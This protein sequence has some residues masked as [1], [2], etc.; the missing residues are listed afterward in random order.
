MPGD[1][2]A[3]YLSLL[4]A[5]YFSLFLHEAGHAVLGWWCG[6]EVTSFGLGLDR[7]L[8]LVRW[9]GTRVYFSLTRSTQGIT[10]LIAPMMYPPRYRQILM[11]LGGC[12]ANGVA[13]LTALLFRL[14]LPWGSDVWLVLL[15]WNAWIGLRNLVP[16]QMRLGKFSLRSDGAKVWQ[17]LCRGHLP[18]H[19]EES[20]RTFTAMRPFWEGVF[21]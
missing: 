18:S 10:W 15:G 6:Y 19:V 21:V 11:L 5:M 3:L 14:L 1:H 8:F 4:P 13:A 9:R 2:L 12:L 17:L 20:I 7:P 16:F